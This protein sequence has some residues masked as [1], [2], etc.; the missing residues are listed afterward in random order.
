MRGLTSE[1]ER[2]LK[3][4]SQRTYDSL[5]RTIVSVFGETVADQVTYQ[6][7]EAVAKELGWA[8]S[9][10]KT[11]LRYMGR[12]GGDLEEGY[13]DYIPT[14]DDIYW[15]RKAMGDPFMTTL[16]LTGCRLNEMWKMRI[17]GKLLIIKSSHG[18]SM[19]RIKLTGLST[20]RFNEVS[21]WVNFESKELGMEAARKKWY[22]AKQKYKLE[23]D[24]TPH[25]FR[26]RKVTLLSE[27][28]MSIEDIAAV[29]GHKSST[30]T[31]RYLHKD[32]G[33]L[34]EDI[35]IK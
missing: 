24:C 28:G 7:Y 6:D 10:F 20:R 21:R 19:R 29:V 27:N 9:T 12:E 32:I 3:D 30:T 11:Y 25:A 15:L 14:D 18:S 34:A 16:Q 5:R 26:H 35:L 22:R 8:E 31:R 33:A 1:R 13:R 4:N 2:D 17:E 23:E